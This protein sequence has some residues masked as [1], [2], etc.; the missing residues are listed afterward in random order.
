MSNA[1]QKITDTKKIRWNVRLCSRVVAGKRGAY[2]LTSFFGIL[3]AAFQFV[4]LESLFHSLWNKRIFFCSTKSPK[5]CKLK[6]II[7]TD[8]A[9]FHAFLLRSF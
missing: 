3:P 8:P 9:I 2:F 1:S 6:K 4:P 5:P 7:L